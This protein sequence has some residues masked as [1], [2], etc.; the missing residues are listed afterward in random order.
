MDN[1]R[2][3]GSGV[4]TM[5][6]ANRNRVASKSVIADDMTDRQRQLLTRLCRSLLVGFLHPSGKALRVHLL[7]MRFEL[8]RVILAFFQGI[9]M[10]ANY[11]GRLQS[12]C[13]IAS[14]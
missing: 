6:A 11:L 13:Q 1:T 2:Q 14:H 7:G 10:L 3:N 9:R 5:P 4:L 12:R 8:V